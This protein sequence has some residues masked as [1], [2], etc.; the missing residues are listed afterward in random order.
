MKTATL[1]VV[2]DALEAYRHQQERNT[3]ILP[4]IRLQTLE[5]I[6]SA[7]EEVDSIKPIKGARVIE[8][9]TAQATTE[10]S[11]RSARS[12]S[13]PTRKEKPKTWSRKG[14]CPSCKVGTGSKH[15]KGCKFLYE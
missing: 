14:T 12:K 10:R 8:I 1:E 4:S 3:F 15:A 7:Q 13:R 6:K 2:K 11:D 9:T 5:Q